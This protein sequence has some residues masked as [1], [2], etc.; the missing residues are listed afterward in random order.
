MQ[1]SA[2]DLDMDWQILTTFLILAAAVGILVKRLRSFV[3]GSKVRGCGS[4]SG[5]G[6]STNNSPVVQFVQLKADSEKRLR[7]SPTPV[8]MPEFCPDQIVRDSAVAEK[9]A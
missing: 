4:C 7:R 2:E 9:N 8:N 6:S 1:L 3:Y 5:C